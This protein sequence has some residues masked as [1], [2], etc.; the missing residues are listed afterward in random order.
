[1]DARCPRVVRVVLAVDGV[2]PPYNQRR[3]WRIPC[4][5]R[6]SIGT[7][8]CSV[9][10]LNEIARHSV[11]VGDEWVGCERCAWALWM[12]H[13]GKQCAARPSNLTH[14]TH[15]A[16]SAA[17]NRRRRKTWTLPTAHRISLTFHL[18]FIHS[19][20]SVVGLGRSN[21]NALHSNHHSNNRRKIIFHWME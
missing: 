12:M 17:D 9:L 10:F 13:D 5:P 19:V 14:N 7:S 8:V 1:M 18:N 11:C 15:T 20:S 21:R 3:K 16:T 4:G 6:M 2:Y